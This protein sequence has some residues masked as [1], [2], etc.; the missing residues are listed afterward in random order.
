MQLCS[1]HVLHT[2]HYRDT[3]HAP[4]HETGSEYLLHELVWVFTAALN[5]FRSAE[6]VLRL[7]LFILIDGHII[8]IY[9]HSEWRGRGWGMAKGLKDIKPWPI[10]SGGDRWA[11]R[12]QIDSLRGSQWWW[13]TRCVLRGAEASWLAVVWCGGHELNPSCIK[14]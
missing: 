2:T 4:V 14:L 11:L 13:S 8:Y 3:A 1:K 5:M 12:G 7:N 9:T 10:L 6:H